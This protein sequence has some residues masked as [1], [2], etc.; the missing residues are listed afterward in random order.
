MKE[1]EEKTLS[2]SVANLAK[3]I[4][5]LRSKR[6]LQIADNPKKFLFYNFISGIASGLGT[7]VGASIVFAIIIWFL[8]KLIFVPHLGNWIVN[9]LNYVQS[10]RI[11]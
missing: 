8:T 11:R 10:S 2:E 3:I 6:Y 9:L 4:K 5:E 7:V 1:E